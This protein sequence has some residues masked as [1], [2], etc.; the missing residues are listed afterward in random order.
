MRASGFLNRLS[1]NWRFFLLMVLLTIATGLLSG[2]TALSA[3]KHFW[4]LTLKIWPILL[5]VFALM[6][7]INY[8]LTP[9]AIVRHLTGRGPKKW[10][11]AIVGGILSVGPVYLWYP[12]LADIRKRGLSDGW[13]ACFLYNRAVKI[14]LLPLAVY[15]FNW[16]YVVVLTA[17]M[18]LASIA[19]AYIINN[20]NSA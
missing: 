7:I 18:I 13:I 19:Q 2:P 16:Q 9:K 10:L 8:F 4:K 12:L 6:A 1:G 11:I 5:L 17:V 14:P 20:L 3:L 15:Y